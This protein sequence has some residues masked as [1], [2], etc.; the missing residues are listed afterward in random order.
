MN[1]GRFPLGKAVS[2][3]AVEADGFIDLERLLAAARRQVRV[4]ALFGALGLALGVVYLLFTP[5]VYTASTNILLDDSLTK[6]AED[7]QM[8]P[9]GPQ[10]DS[11]VLSEVEILKSARLARAVVE[12]RHLQ[13]DEAFLDPPV[14][15]LAR[16]KAAIKGVL[17]VFSG[18]PAPGGATEEAKIGRAAAILQQ[19]LTAERVGRSFVI[20]VSY[21]AN[22]PKLAGSIARAYAD[23]YLSDHLDANFDA[24]QRATVWLQGRLDDLRQSSQDAALEVEK[25]RA[26]HGLTAARGELVSD[27]QLSD[28][29][30]QLIL[31]QADTANALARYNQFRSIVDGGPENA[32]KNATVPIEKGSS[33][34]NT[35]VLTEL[36]TR[37]LGMAKREQDIS[38]RFGKDHPQAVALRPRGSRRDPADFR[39]TEAPHRKL[40]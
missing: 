37:Y 29:N 7:K 21:S 4:V 36:R 3:P 2:D 40:P 38:A 5:P 27:Q 35:S 26:A 16:A 15:P 1:Q 23:A 18:R 32:V 6:F 8:P 30:S 10:G 14:S 13:G 39:G 11:M 22:D 9:L 20:D 25:Y 24:T 33:G 12:A 17:G 19:N 28:L 31:A 34:T